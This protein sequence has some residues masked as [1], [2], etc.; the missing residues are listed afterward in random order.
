MDVYNQFAKIFYSV[1]FV[2][3]FT[4]NVFPEYT[5]QLLAFNLSRNQA[6][7]KIKK[8]KKIVFSSKVLL[9]KCSAAMSF[10]IGFK[11]VGFFVEGKN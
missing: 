7:C 4:S 9:G 11:C 2:F 8:E 10:Q 6:K 3:I 1:I 5:M